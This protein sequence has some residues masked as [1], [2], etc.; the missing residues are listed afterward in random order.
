MSTVCKKE[1]NIQK[2]IQLSA[3]SNS[4][5][6]FR[7]NSGKAWQ[8]NQTQRMKDGS[9][10]IKDPRPFLGHSPGFSDLV[11]VTET[12]ITQDMVGKT[13]GV[14]TFIEVKT[15]DGRIREDQKTFLAAMKKRGAIAGI[16][17]SVSDF[18]ELVK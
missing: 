2:Q 12:V 15:A 5:V 10:L 1:S 6:L 14:A 17:R 9:L 8:G 11:G 16:A 4:C 13:I 7:A 18:E 3:S